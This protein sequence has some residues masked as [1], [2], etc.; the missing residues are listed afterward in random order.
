MAKKEYIARKNAVK[1]HECG[2]ENLSVLSRGQCSADRGSCHD[3]AGPG[4]MHQHPID[5]PIV[6]LT[7]RY[8]A[9]MFIFPPLD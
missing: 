2:S 3:K 4:R 7:T 9:L 5:A 6:G 8:C 1:C